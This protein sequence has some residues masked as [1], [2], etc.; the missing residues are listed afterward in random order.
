V[1]LYLKPQKYESYQQEAKY[2]GF[3]ISIEGIKIDP[4]KTHT[5]QD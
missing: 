3:I 1:G 4:E 5:M 2:L